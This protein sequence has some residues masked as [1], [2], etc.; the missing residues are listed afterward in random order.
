MGLDSR[1]ARVRS[2]KRDGFQL[3]HHAAG[4][5]FLFLEAARQFLAQAP[6]RAFQIGDGGQVAVERG[7]RADRFRFP[8]GIDD[9]CVH[10]P[11]AADQGG[12]VVAEFAHR[13]AFRQ[14]LQLAQPGD[15]EGL[16]LAR[17]GGADAGQ[18][19]DRFRAPA[20]RRLPRRRS[21]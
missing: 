1:A 13:L 11:G 14:R 5:Q 4:G 6:E 21:P 15:A 2:A 12:S 9:A 8:C 10:A 20:R 17:Q 3:Q 16:Q 18:Q 19:A 7:F